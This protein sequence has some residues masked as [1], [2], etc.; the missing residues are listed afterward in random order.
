MTRT[1]FEEFDDLIQQAVERSFAEENDEELYQAAQDNIERLN[2]L[3]EKL[4]KQLGF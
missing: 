1:E 3:F 2:E 4:R